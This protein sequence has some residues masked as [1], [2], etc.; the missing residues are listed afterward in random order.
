MRTL[1]VP[2]LMPSPTHLPMVLEK[3]P[4]ASDILTSRTEILLE[5]RGEVISRMVASLRGRGATEVVAEEVAEQ[6]I[7]DCLRPGG[8]SLLAKFH[9]RCAMDAW[10]LR[11]A[12]NRMV[13]A[14]RRTAI[15]ALPG[16]ENPFHNA[17]DGDAA[18]SAIVRRALRTA[19]ESLPHQERVLLWLRHGFG[20]SQ[21]K[22]CVAWRCGAPAMSRLLARIRADVH[23]RVLRAIELEEPGLRLGWEEICALCG[24]DELYC[25]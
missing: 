1:G 17:A 3:S 24:D 14:R 18:L 11:V 25:R 8:E 6:V 21:K 15:A 5:S 19:L 22:L 20:V 7:A 23:R 12:I 9:G 13:S 10:L 16:A 2:G 4:C